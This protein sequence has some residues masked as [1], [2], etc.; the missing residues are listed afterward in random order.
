MAYR[1]RPGL[2]FCSIGSSSV[3]LDLPHNRY[4]Q[5]KPMLEGPFRRFVARAPVSP[6]ELNA[7][8]E[9]RVVE[10]AETATI[11]QPAT[12]NAARWSSQ[13][14]KH[15]ECSGFDVACALFA[16]HRARKRLAQS[17]LK[18][19]L[20]RLE[21]AVSDLPVSA[22]T[23]L[24]PGGSIIRAFERSKLIKSPADL[25]LPRSIAIIDCLARVRLR[26]RLV[27]G[28]KLAPFAAHAWAQA[29]DDVLNDSVEEVAKYTPILA[30]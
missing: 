1:L 11:L 17:S 8:C 4:F 26:A 28:V 12:L 13:A 20:D 6:E 18:L 3:F 29:E 7:L 27:I 14:I 2:T 22:P 25:C 19:E 23:A 24:S 30:L 21:R 10:E 5:L 9:A 16:Q 15:G